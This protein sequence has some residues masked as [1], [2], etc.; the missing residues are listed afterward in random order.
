M[1]CSLQRSGTTAFLTA[2]N[3]HPDVETIGGVIKRPLKNGGA[4]PDYSVYDAEFDSPYTVVR[5]NFGRET[6]QQCTFSPFRDDDDIHRTRPLFLIKD[7]VQ[8]WNSWARQGWNQFEHFKIAYQ[9]LLDLYAQVREVSDRVRCV[10]Q[11]FLGTVP[12]II[13]PQILENW[14]IPYDS[15]VVYWEDESKVGA[16]SLNGDFAK[17]TDQIRRDEARNLHETLQT[18]PPTYR[19]VIR[20]PE[21]SLQIEIADLMDLYFRYSAIMLET[22]DRY[23]VD[24]GPSDLG[25]QLE[26]LRIMDE[27]R[28]KH[29][30]VLRG[31]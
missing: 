13:F 8:V 23:I 21:N 11:E 18:G 25:R 20:R 6:V 24:G 30:A 27:A 15:R 26:L 12:Q 1:V 17:T 31:E 28:R 2:L 7:P 14:G 16:Y 19:T 3:Q 29:L 4:K 10:A 9:H 22:T 5:S